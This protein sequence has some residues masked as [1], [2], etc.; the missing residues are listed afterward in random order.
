VAPDKL[1]DNISNQVQTLIS[2]ADQVVIEEVY[3]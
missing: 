3:G 1:P 2:Q